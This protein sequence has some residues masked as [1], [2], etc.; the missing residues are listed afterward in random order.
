MLLSLYLNFSVPGYTFKLDAG[1]ECGLILSLFRLLPYPKRFII[2]ILSS[3]VKV[4]HFA[5]SSLVRPQPMQ[6]P[7][8]LFISQILLQGVI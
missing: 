2:A 8:L 7:E 1:Y 3:C 6:S 5:I 4:V